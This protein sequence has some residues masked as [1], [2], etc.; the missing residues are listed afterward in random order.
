M[1]TC[2]S[3]AYDRAT[4]QH[5]YFWVEYDLE[6]VAA[7]GDSTWPSLEQEFHGPYNCPH[8]N[9]KQ[10]DLYARVKE[11]DNGTDVK[12]TAQDILHQLREKRHD[13]NLY[14]IQQNGV[15]TFNDENPTAEPMKNLPLPDPYTGDTF[16]N[17]ESAGGFGMPTVGNW[18]S[19][20]FTQA[21]YKPY[22]TM[23]QGFSS[24]MSLVFDTS[25]RNRIMLLSVS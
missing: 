25:D 1:A 18:W 16:E 12:V 15:N 20:P 8:D 14:I 3:Y 13:N 6:E 9:C 2:S 5:E 21:M 7:H 19:H 11:I 17:T 4:F 10:G 24:E 22:G 23:G